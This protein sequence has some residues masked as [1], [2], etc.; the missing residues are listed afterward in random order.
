MGKPLAD[1]RIVIY[2]DG[3]VNTF[4][5]LPEGRQNIGGSAVLIIKNSFLLDDVKLK[6]KVEGITISVAEL[7][8]IKLALEKLSISLAPEEKKAALLEI[9]SDSKVSIDSLTIY[10]KK[11]STKLDD[12]GRWLKSNNLPV[13]NQ[14]I[15]KEILKLKDNFKSVTFTHVT[16]HSDFERNNAVDLMAKEAVQELYTTLKKALL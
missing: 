14:E 6:A 12:Q 2:T 8:A 7:L 4:K 9:Y 11:W 10:Y 3:S 13:D 15:I 1:E 16:A 5:D